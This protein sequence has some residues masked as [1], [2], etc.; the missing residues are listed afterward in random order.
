MAWA[1]SLGSG[2]AAAFRKPTVVIAA[3]G[4]GGGESMCPSA[5]GL[6]WPGPADL[7]KRQR[8]LAVCSHQTTENTQPRRSGQ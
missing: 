3:G 6:G 7:A 4:P 8:R 2:A 5:T 1:W